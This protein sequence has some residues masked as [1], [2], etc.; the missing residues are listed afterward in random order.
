MYADGTRVYN[1]V[2]DASIKAQ[3]LDDLDSL[4][5]CTDTWQLRFNADKCEKKS[6]VIEKSSVEKD[7]GV[8]RIE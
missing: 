6:S 3:L 8:Y 2:K 5:N 7:L 4:F 1:T